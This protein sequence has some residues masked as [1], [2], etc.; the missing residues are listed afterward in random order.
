MRNLNV[1]M[2][3][4]VFGSFG[5]VRM[6][7]GKQKRVILR[8]VYNWNHKSWTVIREAFL[9]KWYSLIRSG[10]WLV[11]FHSPAESI[12]RLKTL[13]FVLWISLRSACPEAQTNRVYGNP[14][15]IWNSVGARSKLDYA[16]CCQISR[17]C[18]G[19]IVDY[20]KLMFSSVPCRDFYNRFYV[21]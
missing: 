8:M 21:V 13:S 18:P 10:L 6:V 19:V 5:L 14:R 4:L 3:W 12:S 9:L 11:H 7:L 15:D 2:S 1:C 16:F 17:R 20:Y